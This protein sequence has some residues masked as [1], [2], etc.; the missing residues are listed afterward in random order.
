MA[1]LILWSGL[2]WPTLH[3]DALEFVKRCEQCQCTKPPVARQEML[4]R[5]IMATRAFA[6][7]GM[8]FVGPIKPLARH[9]HAE[10]IIV[11]TDYLT[12]WVEAKATVKNDARTTAKFLYENVF[13]RH[14]LPIE[15]VSD[16]GVHFINEVIEFLL[17]EF[18]ILHR[19]SAPYHPQANG[20]AESTNKT[21]C[22]A[23]TKIVSDSRTDWELKLPS[24]IWAYRTAYKTAVGTT[25]FELVYGQNAIL[26]IEFLVPMLRVATE[27]EWTGHE[28]SKRVTDL[29]KL[30]EI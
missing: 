5:P 25:P 22:T 3:M 8:Y 15:I 10:Y 23:L 16:Q 20:Q 7:W 4:L 27:L 24:V 6:K 30:D 17:A 11:A 19:R 26:P 18:M 9:T 28:L 12:K 29:E 13:T 21:L 1:K 14:G 2:W